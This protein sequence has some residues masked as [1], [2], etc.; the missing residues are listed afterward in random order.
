LKREHK[1]ILVIG[2]MIAAALI[3]FTVS[4][5][6]QQDWHMNGF[7][8]MRGSG[9]RGG[10]AMMLM[11]V[12]FWIALIG[13]IVWVFTAVIQKSGAGRTDQSSDAP[14][15]ILK[16]RYARGEIDK[17]EYEAKKKDLS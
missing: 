4:I 17:D 3:I 5:M 15:D 12:L 8:M 10:S 9:I 13:L 14:M 6:L 1:I 11:M 2:A 7:G 16:Q